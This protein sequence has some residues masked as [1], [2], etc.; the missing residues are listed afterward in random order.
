VRREYGHLRMAG[1]GYAVTAAGDPVAWV[2]T[3]EAETF[4]LPAALLGW[5]QSTIGSTLMI[6]GSDSDMSPVRSNSGSSTATRTRSSW[7]DGAGDGGPLTLAS[8][9]G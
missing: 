1:V 5:A 6:I 3:S 8:W 2:E 4:R 9:Y 7:C